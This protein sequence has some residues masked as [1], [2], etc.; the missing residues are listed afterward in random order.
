MSSNYNATMLF[1]QVLLAGGAA[2]NACDEDGNTALHAAAGDARSS[3]ELIRMLVRYRQR[4]ELR[5]VA[6]LTCHHWFTLT[7]VS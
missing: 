3:P 2:V 5:L 1:L 4:L 6:K 7:D